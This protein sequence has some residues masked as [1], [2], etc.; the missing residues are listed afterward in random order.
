MRL[1]WMFATS[2]LGP[3]IG[4]AQAKPSAAIPA[5]APP[6]SVSQLP[7]AQRGVAMPLSGTH[8][9][10]DG[11]QLTVEASG[12]PMPEVLSKVA[13]Q[14]GMKITGG[15]P[16]EHLYGKYGPASVQ[17]V[18]GEL[19]DGLSVNMMLV[20][21]SATKPKELILTSRTGGPTPPSTRPIADASSSPDNNAVEPV[22]QMAP[23]SG[24]RP[25]LP[26]P[27]PRR[28]GNSTPPAFP[29][30]GPPSSAE[31]NS[32]TNEGNAASSTATPDGSNADEPQ[33]PNGVK[34]PEQ[35]FEELRRRAA[36]N[37]PQ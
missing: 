6:P 31:N 14:T 17:A 29:A 8:I 4:G 35:I 22:E 21:T 34:T 18:L 16:D 19:F 28:P 12:E 13:R 15:V 7:S 24:A 30:I 1:L 36:A 32:S 37:Q 10:W 27:E 23:L 3:A 33:S 11:A 5:S 25:L 2:L 20:N 9:S 26:I